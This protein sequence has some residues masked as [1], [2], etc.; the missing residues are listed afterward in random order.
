M[1]MQ[2]ESKYCPDCDKTKNITEF[3]K[4]G[5]SYM[6]RCKLCHNQKSR[7]WE[8]DN[9][10]KNRARKVKWYKDNP[11]SKRANNLQQH[12]NATLADYD[13][14]FKEQGGLCAACGQ[15]ETNLDKRTKQVKN[16]HVDHCHKSEKIRALLCGGCNTALG[17]LKDDPARIRLLLAYA[18]KH[19]SEEQE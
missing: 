4:N 2:E 18:E 11:G 10:D 1:Q 15:P 17:H 19:I 12:Y 3:Y 16:L 9:P 5:K 13:Y 14:L 8:K 6:K 7:Q